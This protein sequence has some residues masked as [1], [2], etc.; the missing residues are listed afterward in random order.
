MS[1]AVSRRPAGAGLGDLL[2]GARMAVTGGRAGWT[3]TLLTALGV[4]VGVAMLLLAAAVPGAIDSRG[5]RTG[6]RSE[7]FVDGPLPA[8]PD[9]LLVLHADGQFRQRTVRGWLVRPEG[10]DAPVPPGLTTL[11]GP[12]EAVVSPALRAVLDSPDGPL[13]VARLGGARVVGVIGADGLSGPDELAWYAGRADLTEEWAGRLDRFGGG[14]P[15]ED[16]GPTL[17]L[18]VV[19]VFVVLLLPVVVFLGAAVRFGGDQRDRR[20]AAI[21]LLGADQGMVRRIAAGEATAAALLGLMVGGGLFLAGRQLAWFVSFADYSFYPADLRPAVPLVTLVVLAV[22]ALAIAVALLALR[23]VAVEPLGVTRRGRPARRRLW[24]R[25]LLPV[26]GLG[27]LYPATGS[28]PAPTADWRIAAGA[29]LL[30]AGTVT[31]LPWLVDLVVRPLRGGPPGWQ[32]AVRRLQLD[33]ATSAR[34]VSGVAVAVAGTIGLQMLIAGVQDEF[35]RPSGQD[36]TRAQAMVNLPGVAEPRAALD[37]LATVEGVTGSAATLSTAAAPA[38]DTNPNAV[39]TVRIGDCAALAEYAEVDG[40]A[41]GDVFLARSGD[42]EAGVE[43]GGRIRLDEDWTIPTATRI[44]P[45]RTDPTG[46]R[47]QSALLLTPTAAAGLPA[48]HLNA[49]ALL[50]FD[51]ADR[52]T[53][54]RVRATVAAIDPPIG[55]VLEFRAVREDPG[56]T[57]V[58]TGLTAG[59]VITL[60]LLGISLLVGVLEQLRDRRPLLAA[61]VAVGTPRRVLGWSVLA[62]TGVPVLVGLVLA[63]G[64]GTATGA[65]LLVMVGAPVV[66]SWPVV[67]LGTS[68][69]AAVVVLVTAAS[70]PVLW[71]LTRPDGLRVE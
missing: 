42:L 53:V 50:T 69:G 61:L 5:E 1:A 10:P 49:T 44:V 70:L 6:A 20:L 27:L 43:P 12:G 9:T 28:E 29:V 15:G 24:W 22:P 11:P 25:L 47:A 2:M 58:R 26:V 21:R 54:E 55:Q 33:S 68:L 18:L 46:G 36:L 35:R 13:L 38:G 14:G 57:K 32:L 63:A 51:P 19:I 60:L 23:R 16:L 56:F 66:L 39:V 31:V 52:D 30:L 71:R 45:A 4:G 62:Q 65:V 64:V 48:R 8:G 41:D 17:N 7:P 40:C 59:A 37:R 67:G 34:L 3:R